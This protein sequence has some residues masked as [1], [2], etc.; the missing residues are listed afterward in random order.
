M[1]I[2]VPVRAVNRTGSTTISTPDQNRTSFPQ[3]DLTEG[4]RHLCLWKSL[5]GPS[6]GVTTMKL[7]INE[8]DQV[9]QRGTRASGFSTSRMKQ[10]S[11]MFVFT[12]G[13]DGD[14]QITGT[15]V[16]GT[17]RTG[18][19]QI[20]CINL[21]QGL[22][23]DVD[24]FYDQNAVTDL[25]TS[26]WG[27]EGEKASITFTPDGVSDYLVIGHL[28]WG[29]SGTDDRGF[30]IRDQTAGATLVQTAPGGGNIGNEE[31]C[32]MIMHVLTAPAASELTLDTEYQ[33][34]GDTNKEVAGLFIL[35]LSAFESYGFIQ[36]DL[37]DAAPDLNL[38]SIGSF[39]VTPSTDGQI[40]MLSS[41]LCD[42]DSGF[43]TGYGMRGTIEFDGIVRAQ[44][45]TVSNSYFVSGSAG[46][47]VG[48]LWVGPA[49]WRH[50]Q[51]L[52]VEPTTTEG[53]LECN[54]TI[55]SRIRRRTQTL[56]AFAPEV[57]PLPPA[58]ANVG[59]SNSSILAVT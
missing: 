51:G 21:D 59:I 45:N 36:T 56:V 6:G 3:S 37:D 8:V 17:N 1:P 33:S 44:I 14:V 48:E 35:R 10:H 9:G 29:D 23:E 58:K 25:A 50:L 57:N 13:A 43:E 12:A 49:F 31:Q 7:R 11:G 20:I 22:V 54:Q 4:D 32:D 55:I 30:R 15:P 42:V 28:K 24:W 47:A 5:T 53:F 16:S 34:L 27:S 26:P 19:E 40:V 46:P 52:D 39:E 38:N 18:E 41:F 2:L